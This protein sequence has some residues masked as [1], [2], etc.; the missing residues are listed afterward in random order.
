MCAFAFLKSPYDE[1]EASNVVYK[2]MRW[3]RGKGVELQAISI[4][5]KEK[6][7]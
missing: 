7:I 5:S 3:K 2:S 1:N 4:Y 6:N